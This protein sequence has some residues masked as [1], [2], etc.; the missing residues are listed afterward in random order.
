MFD[1]SDSTELGPL[2]RKS[3]QLHEELAQ[4]L[5]GKSYGYRKVDTYSVNIA[6][7]KVGKKSSK[8]AWLDSEKIENVGTMGTTK[9]TAQV[10][11]YKFTNA[12]IDDAKKRGVRVRCGHGVKSLVWDDS[13]NRIS[14]VL[15]ENDREFDCDAA[16]I[17]MGP[18]SGDLPIK[19]NRSP[20]GKLPIIAARAH[21]IVLKP[22][23]DVPAQALF[24]SMQLGR[25]LYDP[26]VTK[27]W[28]Q[29]SKYSMY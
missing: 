20:R 5:N 6:S 17:C 25:K 22:R 23:G 27:N 4:E 18:W 29:S 21:S 7:S 28:D 9:T 12:L 16:V 15:L 11:P 14:G 13:K 24:C 1:R 26:E 19:S 10:H 3:F 2:S 8:F